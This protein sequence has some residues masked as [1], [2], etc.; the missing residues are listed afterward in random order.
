MQNDERVMIMIDLNVE[1]T[2][3]KENIEKIKTRM[4]NFFLLIISLFSGLINE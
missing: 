4:T 1:R 2:S 3:Y